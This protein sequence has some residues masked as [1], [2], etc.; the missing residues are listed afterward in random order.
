MPELDRKRFEEKDRVFRDFAIWPSY[1]QLRTEAW[2]TNF[3]ADEID[4]AQRLV[5]NFIYYDERMTDALLG[6]SI[7]R[8]MSLVVNRASHVRGDAYRLLDNTAFVMCEGEEPNPVDSGNYFARKLRDRFK[9]SETQIL[10]PEV[11]LRQMEHYS[12]IVFFDD[13][14][15]SGNQLL[16]TLERSHKID[17]KRKSFRSAAAS[18]DVEFVYCSCL[19]TEQAVANI[20]QHA[21][22][23]C[24]LSTH[25]LGP[26]DGVLPPSARIWEP[27]EHSAAL[28]FIQ[29]ASQ[30]AGYV[31]SNGGQD[32][33]RGFH[34]LG[35]ALA[36]NH[37]I[38]DASLPLF[39]SSRN[40]WEPLVS[41]QDHAE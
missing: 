5:S 24:V 34:Q 25:I 13:F 4:Y 39:F 14:I 27:H 2:L 16:R 29:S 33:W 3:T 41:R 15:G 35:L 38:P 40:G 17:G 22:E 8:Y 23:V 20:S 7:Q 18:H 28:N 30:R 1:D 26:R 36:F 19:G 37:G 32:D 10:R 31:A 21:P 11:A 12:G 6:A 9:I